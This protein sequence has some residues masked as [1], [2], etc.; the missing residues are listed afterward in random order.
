M[1]PPHNMRKPRAIM[2][3]LFCQAILT[4]SIALSI[5][6]LTGC[7]TK[8]V[9]VPSDKAVVRVLANRPYTAKVNGYFVPDA[10]MVEILNALDKARIEGH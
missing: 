1:P 10:R 3:K 5:L 8:T 2:P 6:T 4:L 9:I 7:Q